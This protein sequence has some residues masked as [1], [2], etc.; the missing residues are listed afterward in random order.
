MEPELIYLQSLWAPLSMKPHAGQK[1]LEAAALPCL[2]YEL[3]QDKTFSSS[4]E[5]SSLGFT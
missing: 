1:Q 4:L 5:I 2:K 3:L